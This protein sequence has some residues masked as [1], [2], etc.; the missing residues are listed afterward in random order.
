MPRVVSNTLDCMHV[1]LLYYIET[2]AL[3]QHVGEFNIIFLSFAVYGTLKR[4][5]FFWPYMSNKNPKVGNNEVTPFHFVAYHGLKD[6]ADFL[7]EELQ[8]AEICLIKDN[9]DRSASIY[10]IFS[11]H[12]EIILSFFQKIDFELINPDLFQQILCEAIR[13][14]NLDFL[15]AL[16]EK[17]TSTFQRNAVDIAKNYHSK[18]MS[19]NHF[20]IVQYLSKEFKDSK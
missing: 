10:T 2:A 17:Q 11:G 13:C 3:Y 6:V 15:K 5:K 19:P 8:S 16:L 7:I 18:T 12:A 14:G 20:N 9:M 4:L 1:A